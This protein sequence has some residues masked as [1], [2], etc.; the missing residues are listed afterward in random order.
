MEASR[1]LTPDSTGRFRAFD[2]IQ[3]Y[4]QSWVP[5]RGIRAVV[6][7]L[8]GVAEHGGRYRDTA[9]FLKEKGYALETFDMRG[10]GRSGGERCF[11]EDFPE[12]LEDLDVFLERV[13]E[14]IPGKP[15]FFFGHGMGGTVCLLHIITRRIAPRG[16]LL[17]APALT[18]GEEAP[19]LWRRTTILFGRLGGGAASRKQ[20]AALFSRDPEVIARRDEDPHVFQGRIPSRT[21]TAM[22]KAGRVIRARMHEITSPL[23][24][25]HGERDRVV[26]PEGSRILLGGVRSGDKTGRFYPD[27]YHEILNEPE[28]EKVWQDIDAWLAAHIRSGDR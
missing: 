14:R 5:A 18:A 11:V 21:I 13:R 17:S 27:L 28:K 16:I 6:V 15:L 1:A 3:L 8:H 24:V 7:L 2:G 10:H 23:L 22:L 12:Y 25:M 20:D 19:S 9:A 26:D 4:E